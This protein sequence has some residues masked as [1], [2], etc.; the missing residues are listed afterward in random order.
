MVVDGKI[1]AQRAR[2][3]GA[4]R[5]RVWEGKIATLERFKDD[6]REVA[7][8]TNAVSGSRISTT[9]NPTT[10]SRTSR[11]RRCCASSPRPSPRRCAARRRSRS[12]FSLRAAAFVVDRR[13]LRACALAEGAYHHGGRSNA[14]DPVPAGESFA[15][16][17]AT[18]AARDQ[19]SRAQQVQRL[20]RGIRQPRTVAARRAGH[21]RRSA[22]TARSSTRRCARS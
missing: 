13:A 10:L 20:D 6:A 3:A 15:Q 19:G 21:L 17:Q 9:S 16:G 22:A 5:P 7:R 11:W 1:A 8:A 2:A 12:S 18:G 4:R 14:T